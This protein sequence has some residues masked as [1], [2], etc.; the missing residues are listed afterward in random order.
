[1]IA[2]TTPAS[3]AAGATPPAVAHA[4]IPAPVS[5]EALPGETLELTAASRIAVVAEDDA[6]DAVAERFARWLRRSTGFALPVGGHPGDEATDIVL[7]VAPA[8]DLGAEGYRLRVDASGVRIDAAAP[9]GLFRALTT[10]RQ[11]LPVS[12]EATTVQPGPWTV[13]GV[14]ISDRPRFEYRGTMLDVA[15][16]FFGVDDV[17]RYID[18]I[19]LYKVNV[20]HLH[21]T[22]DQGWR[23]DVPGWPRLAEVGGAG[24][25]DGGPG[26]SYTA[27]DYARIVGHAAEHFIEV[28]PEIDGPG[29]T[30][31]ALVA[32]PELSCDGVAPPLFHHG[33]I[34]EVSLCA[35]AD[36]TYEFLGDVFD[37]LAT[38]RGRF[39]HIGGDE[40]IGTSHD[41]FVQFVPRAA[42]LV[43][44]RGRTPVMWHEAAATT[45]PPGSVVQYWG[46][47]QDEATELA[48]RAVAAGARLILSPGN[49]A[50][51]DMKYDADTMLGLEW[52]GLVPVSASYAWEPA[53]LIEGVAEG[54][55][56]G[57]ESAL[58]SETTP[59]RAAVEYLAF[60]RLAGIAEIAWSPATALVWDDYRLRLA[61]QAPRWDV[62]GVNY[63]RSP[64]VPW[65]A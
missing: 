26:G 59:N 33:G 30:S 55:I 43:V 6:A 31:A 51:L 3:R 56:L 48:G 47:G 57:V 28:V 25:I 12:A 27:A 61:A 53:T 7:A 14:E 23:L 40:A 18:L 60:P 10:L 49:H 11:L 46:V 35:S 62:L 17:L 63:F 42:A 52:A 1:M 24:D 58:W 13:E 45:M 44:D 37:A 41:D 29:H 36:V 19:S 20:L 38:E 39:I 15:R 21:L 64:E 16:H 4:I 32:Y 34:S 65:P 9:A 2:M 22:D 50:Y 54:S 5:H 8:D